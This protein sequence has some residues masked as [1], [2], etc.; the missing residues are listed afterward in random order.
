MFWWQSSSPCLNLLWLSEVWRLLG[1]QLSVPVAFHT[2][3]QQQRPW[4]S[5]CAHPLSNVPSA[6]QFPSSD[7]QWI[8]HVGSNPEASVAVV[9]SLSPVP[10]WAFQPL[11]G[12]FSSER[13]AL[14]LFFQIPP[15]RYSSPLW[16]RQA[17]SRDSF[18]QCEFEYLYSEEKR[19]SMFS[20]FR[21]CCCR[22]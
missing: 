2:H 20:C 17:C 12:G 14:S 11:L 13:F 4:L 15:S 8:P 18:L 9:Q 6:H 1:L 7:W 21:V 19:T 3:S 5:H 22:N 10:W 16:Q